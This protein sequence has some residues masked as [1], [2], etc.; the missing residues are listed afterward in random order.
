[1]KKL[2]HALWALGFADGD[3]VLVRDADVVYENDR[4]LYVGSGYDG[5]VDEKVDCSEALISPGF[6]DMDALGDVYYGLLDWEIPPENEKFL[7]WSAE[8]YPK[9]RELFSPQE[10]AWK[11]LYAFVQLIKN[12]ITTAMPITSVYY[13]ANGE[14]FEELAAAAG[15]A[16]RLGLRAYLGPS[17]ICGMHVVAPDGSMSIAYDE[18]AGKAGLEQAVRFVREFDSAYGGLV[19]GV[20][21]PERIELQTEQNLKATRAAADDLGCIVRLHAAQGLLEYAAIKERHGKTPLQYLDSLGFLGPDVA[22][23]H[24]LF[25]QGYSRLPDDPPGDDLDILVKRGVSVIHCPLV[26]SRYGE[27]LESF[28]RY[29][30]HGVNM[31]IGTDTYPT[32]FFVNMRLGT[33]L[34]R[35]IDQ[36]VD[37]NRCA[38]FYRAATLGGAK[39][40][41]RDDL[42]KLAPGAKA[43]IIVVDLS[44]SHIGPLD[45][46]IRTAVNCATGRDVKCSIIDGKT[47]MWNRVIPGVDET[48]LQSQAQAYFA[49]LKAGYRERDYNHLDPA[50]MFPPSFKIV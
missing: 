38:D 16:G 14:T 1:M 44:G 23:P 30:R 24:V 8:Y 3:H 49:K 4:I 25:T 36:Q 35:Y 7:Q 32:D 17:Y 19:K 50:D 39:S 28:G 9:R 21:V 42:G 34:A 41:G 13:K 33:A 20:L 40:L 31:A 43:D 27:A 5:D 46:P 37:G 45:D 29:L 18:N 47:V 12:G 22:I 48:A 15:H 26:Y 6:V 11:S 2:L 10:E